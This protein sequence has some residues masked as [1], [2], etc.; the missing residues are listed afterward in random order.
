M[1][2]E[3]AGIALG[4][5]L[6]A[7]MVGTWIDSASAAPTHSASEEVLRVYGPKV[8][9][10]VK[11]IGYW[12]GLAGHKIVEFTEGS[13]PE[14]AD[15]HTVTVE[16]GSL[17][18]EGEAGVAVGFAGELPCEVT[19]DPQF[20]AEWNV[21]AHELGHCLGFKDFNTGVEG[22]GTVDASYAGVMSYEVW[23]N[24]DKSADKGLLRG[25]WL[26]HTH[27]TEIGDAVSIE[28]G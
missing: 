3:L 18:K 9:A 24:P 17:A 28:R 15:I 6:A 2:L 5:T 23:G 20:V 1:R 13:A 21:F 27:A 4:L 7:G 19:V 10:L 14:Q 26:L 16:F 25:S 8:P 11:G 12:N 22:V